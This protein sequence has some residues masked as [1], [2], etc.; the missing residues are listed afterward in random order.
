MTITFRESMQ[1]IDMKTV[2]HCILAMTSPTNVLHWAALI[3]SAMTPLYNHVLMT[4][5]ATGDDL[6]PI[7][8]EILSF[9]W[10]ETVN[11]ETIQKR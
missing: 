11:A 3:N 6:Q 4:L 1:K 5:P 7:H 10:I 9:L 8:K 2:K